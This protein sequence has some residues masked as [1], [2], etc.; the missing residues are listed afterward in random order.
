MI[1]VGA[2]S[3]VTYATTYGSVGGTAMQY[4]LD[5]ALFKVKA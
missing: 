5:V 2:G 1:R 4:S 3:A